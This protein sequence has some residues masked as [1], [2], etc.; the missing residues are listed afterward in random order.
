MQHFQAEPYISITDFTSPDQ[1]KRILAIPLGKKWIRRWTI[2][3][4]WE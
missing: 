4:A 2:F 3:S 1:V